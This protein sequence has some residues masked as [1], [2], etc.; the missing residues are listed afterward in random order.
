MQ[1]FLSRLDYPDNNKR[2]LHG[3]DPLIGGTPAQVI[4]KERNGRG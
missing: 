2:V 3:P 4:E 1:H